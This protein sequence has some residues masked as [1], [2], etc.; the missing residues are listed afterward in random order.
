MKVLVGWIWLATAVLAPAQDVPDV[1]VA[2][3]DAFVVHVHRGDLD[4]ELAVRLGKQALATLSALA[5]A[6][7]T[8]LGKQKD[9][10]AAPPCELHLW[11][12]IAD[13][14]AIEQKLTGGTFRRNLAFTPWENPQSHIVLQPVL[15]ATVLRVTGVPQLTLRLLSHEVGHQLAY[16]ALPNY[17]FH[18]FW[19]AEGIATWLEDEVLRVGKAAGKATGEPHDAREI[20]RVQSLI[21][22]GK[23]PTLRDMVVGKVLTD[24]DWHDRYAATSLSFAWLWARKS[25]VVAAVVRKVGTLPGDARL[26]ERLAD[27][28]RAAFGAAE[29]QKLD[30][31]FVDWVRRQRPEWDEEL[32]MLDTHATPWVQLAFPD[33]S[34]SAWRRRA[35]PGC[36]VRAVVELLPTDGAQANLLLDRQTASFV[37]VALRAG[38]GVTVM[39]Y[40][41]GEGPWPRFGHADVEVVC[42]R[43]YELRATIVDGELRVD[44]DGQRV[45]ATKVPG[46][47]FTGPWGLGVQAGGG[48]LWHAVEELPPGK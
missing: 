4:A 7:P 5:T 12:N 3:N 2:K 47:S 11:R 22:A 23:L 48:A 9:G 30:A 25:K 31:A 40:R 39:R 14:E 1:V 28:L 10:T 38:T 35:T 43:R 26:P 16:R 6:A 34:A 32:R 17:R 27:E 15:P 29:W 33:A 24:L 8:L 20:V 44:L 21:D 46:H 19:F 42:G 45:L 36:G 13:Y 18:P 41:P 37:S